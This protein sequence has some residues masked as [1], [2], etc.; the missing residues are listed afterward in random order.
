MGF[1]AP[2]NQSARLRLWTV[3]WVL[4]FVHFL[5]QLSRRAKAIWKPAALH[6]AR[7]SAARLGLL[8]ASLTSFLED[9]K[10]RAC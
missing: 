8:L 4:V 10:R 7:L 5:M 9:K 1:P 3:G 2:K 6:Q